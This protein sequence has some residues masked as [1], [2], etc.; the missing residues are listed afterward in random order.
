MTEPE[1]TDQG[2]TP[3]DN[4][5]TDDHVISLIEKI[6][7]ASFEQWYRERQFIQNI[8]DGKPYFNGPSP[9]RQPEYHTPT[10]LKQCHRKIYYQR[11][12][13]P[14]EQPDPEGLYWFGTEFE[15][16]LA[17]EYLGDIT[18]PDAYVRNSIWINFT[19]ETEAGELQIR[20]ETDPVIV[21]E[22]GKPLLPSEIK[23][24]GVDNLTEPKTRHV[25]QVHAYLWGLSQKYDRE[26]TDAV[27]LYTH[28]KTFRSTPFHV[29]FD[30]QF[31]RNTV[32][33]WAETQTQYRQKDLLPQAEPEFNQECNYCTYKH[34]CGQS[35]ADYA[36]A[37]VR[38]FLPLFAEYPRTK[39]KE[40]LAAHTDTNAKLTPTLA[41]C[42]PNLATQY[43][44][45]DWRCTACDATHPWN[46]IDWDGNV[47]TPPVCPQCTSDGIP[48][49]LCG[50]SPAEQ[51][52]VRE[53]IQ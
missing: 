49:P 9:S 35:D 26:L 33:A 45:H 27:L 15:E 41:H 10:K 17:M 7:S 30:S 21:D 24:T 4:A 8:R 31:W 6:G 18:G 19:V 14:E 13:A 40:Y 20:G 51:V 52:S 42:Y 50:P 34:R 22:D 53:E 47:D 48:A 2:S 37:E 43:E 23:T 3:D 38:G 44:V 29:E 39:V 25:A 5:G 28:R 11:R 36:D 46:A 1:S 16:A 12:N 32:L